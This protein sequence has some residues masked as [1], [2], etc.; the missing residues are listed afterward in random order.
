[1]WWSQRGH[2]WQYNTAHAPCI[3]DKKKR[4][5]ANARSNYLILTAFPRQEWLRERAWVVRY[6]YIAYLATRERE[7]RVVFRLWQGAFDVFVFLGYDGSSL[8][9]LLATFWKKTILLLVAFWRLDRTWRCSVYWTNTAV[10][11]W[12]CVV[13]VLRIFV[14]VLIVLCDRSEYW[15]FRDRMTVC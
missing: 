15:H 9:K 7:L 13:S 1:M 11:T 14:Y 5:R 6:T 2:R 3:R 4:Q 10:A 12:I 8:D